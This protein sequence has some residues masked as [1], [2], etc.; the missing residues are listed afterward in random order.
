MKK[1]NPRKPLT[2]REVDRAIFDQKVK[3]K[4]AVPAKVGTQP[5]L[6]IIDKRSTLKIG[7]KIRFKDATH[8]TGWHYGIVD[9]LEPIIFL[10]VTLNTN[11]MSKHKE[12]GD[13][14]IKDVDELIC[15]LKKIKEEHG[16]V[17]IGIKDC[18]TDWPMTIKSINYNIYA[19]ACLIDSIGY[20]KDDPLFSN[21]V[22]NA[23]RIN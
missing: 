6:I 12:G 16:N 23:L 11:T 14:H 7:K 1:D 13:L 15:R 9:R 5:W 10:T 4:E 22:M 17:R 21:R 8:Y 20:H 19:K 3:A 2:A 18:D